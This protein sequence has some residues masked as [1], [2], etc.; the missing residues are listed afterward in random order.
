MKRIIFILLLTPFLTNAQDTANKLIR[1]QNTQIDTVSSGLVTV[2]VNPTTGSPSMYSVN[3]NLLKWNI[4]QINNLQ[5]SLNSKAS[6]SNIPDS[7]SQLVND[8]GYISNYVET[9]PTIYSW[10]KSNIKPVYDW[11]EI[12]N[13]PVI[14]INTNQLTNGSGFI[15]TVPAQSWVSITGKPTFATVANSGSYN[16]LTNKP[17][18]PTVAQQYGTSYTKEWSG[19]VSTSTSTNEYTINISS[20]SFTSIL[21]IQ[22]TGYYSGASASTQPLVSVKSYSTTSIVLVVAE[23]ANTSVLIGGTIDG[24]T[25]FLKVGEI[26]L[27][28]KGN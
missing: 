5:N 26:F 25:E 27:T 21:N 18:I 4:S 7:L 3:K 24:L 16:D 20:A 28:V 8:V 11:T 14:P 12:T 19:K 22:A 1:S 10:A 17:T 13:K 15:T 6:S 2:N 23:S 9:D